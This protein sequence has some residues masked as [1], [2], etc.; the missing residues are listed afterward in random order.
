[1]L[2][3]GVTIPATVPQRSEIPERLMNYP[4]F[5]STTVCNLSLSLSLWYL[6]RKSRDVVFLKFL[7]LKADMTFL[8][9]LC[10]QGLKVFPLLISNRQD[11]PFPVTVPEKLDVYLVIVSSVS[12]RTS[13]RTPTPL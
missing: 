7:S 6:S 12:V 1:M 10:K 5:R 9:L 2:P 3:F 8:V 13:Q 11:I 4:V